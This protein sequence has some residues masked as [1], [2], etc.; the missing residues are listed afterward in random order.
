MIEQEITIQV[1]EN[2]FDTKKI[3]V[4]VPHGTKILCTESYVLESLALYGLGGDIEDNVHKCENKE[5]YI[6]QGE[7]VLI[8]KDKAGVR[9]SKVCSSFFVILVNLYSSAFIAGSPCAR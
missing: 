2:P 4:Q 3:K 9:V 6:T 7:V 8:S 1:G 5:K